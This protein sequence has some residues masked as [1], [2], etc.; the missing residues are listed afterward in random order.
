MVGINFGNFNL[1]ISRYFPLIF[2]HFI[3]IKRIL[4]K[5][6]SIFRMS[7]V[8]Y[9]G[10]S[11]NR[12][13]RLGLMMSTVPPGKSYCNLTVHKIILFSVNL[14]TIYFKAPQL[15][16]LGSATQ[17]VIGTLCCMEMTIPFLFYHYSK[18]YIYS[19]QVENKNEENE[20]FL[21]ESL[22]PTMWGTKKTEFTSNDIRY[23]SK[24]SYFL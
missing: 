6:I 15:A 12:V 2:H 9:R 14:A 22:S 1:V 23:R 3:K 21:I 20:K 18:R 8:I 10:P 13:K 4:L 24:M 19:V 5:H 7:Q 16:E 17:F 11:I